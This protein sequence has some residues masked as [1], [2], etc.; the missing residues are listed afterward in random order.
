MSEP[1]MLADHL[2][3]QTSAILAVWRA[4][5]ERVGDVSE[6]GRLSFTDFVD[7]IPDLL[8]RLA[9]RLRGRPADATVTGKKHGTVRWR[10]GYDIAEVVNE[11]GHL[12]T[13]LTRATADFA[14]K[15]DWD[16][17]SLESANEAIND[18]LDEA[19]AESVRQFQEDSRAETQKA[20]AEVKRR[21]SAIEEA[22]ISAKL[23]KSKLRTILNSLPVGVWVVDAEGT[24]I[25]VNHEAERIQ[26]F[27]HKENVGHA[28]VHRLGGNERVVRTDGT[29]YRP[30]ELPI[31][32]ALRGETIPDEE[33]TWITPSH[34]S[35]V[36]IKAAPLTDPS[37]AIIGAVAAVQDLTNRRQ[38]EAQL[39]H[40]RDLSRTITDTLGEG[41]CTLDTEGRVTFVNPAAVQMLGWSAAEL[42][43]EKLHERIHY[44]RS[45]GTP[46]PAERCPILGV[47]H[48]GGTVQG[49][50]VF[51][52]KDGTRFI[53]AYT[54]SAIVSGGRIIGLAEAFR[55]VT[56]RKGLEARLAASEAQF[57]TIAEKSPV[58]IWRTDVGA[59]CDYVNQTWVEF[60]GPWV[61]GEFTER[62]IAALHPDDRDRVTEQYT[63]AFAR[64]ESFEQIYRI[65]RRDGQ[66]RWLS[67][68]AT[69][70]RDAAGTFLGY[71]G[72]CLDITERINLERALEQQREL[73]EEASRH[74][75]RLV[76]ALSHDARTPLNAVVLAA[77]LLELHFDENAD[78]EVQTCLRTIRHSVRNVLDLLGDLLDLSKIDAGA[79]PAE[80]TRFPVELVLAECVASIEP[81]AR[82]KGLDLRFEPGPLTGKTIETDR[83]KLKQIVS[84]L[85]SNALRYTERGHVR[86][87]TEQT[88]DQVRIV[89]E[90]TGI[91]IDPRDQARIFDEFAVI[92]HPLR[93]EA[94]TGLGLAICR[95]LASLLMGEISLESAVGKGSTFRLVLPSSVLTADSPKLGDRDALQSPTPD[96]GAILIAED[97]L[98]SRQTLAR[99]LRR[100]GFRVLE[101]SNGHDALALVR[102]ESVMAV[103]MDVNMPLMD[104]IE[105]TLT[106]R[107]DPRF[108]ELPIFALTGDVTLVNQ[109]RIGE[110]GVNG[111]LE[112]PVTW[113]ALK[114]ALATLSP[115]AAE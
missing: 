79:T 87:Y 22:W 84:N 91:G 80:I 12:R 89:V 19:T 23:E 101:A 85:L 95:R 43:G 96:Q 71:L 102:G 18:V 10:Q 39:R 82:L 110:A 32:R 66:Y 111:Y 99:V 33:L 77:Q 103:L 36:A 26:G 49:D 31:V 93:T 5:V 100:M 75:T 28:N 16:I 2:D 90:D 37:G 9:E 46:Y 108:R 74:K 17:A 30:D 105:A 57:R 41:L 97:H 47:L 72:S 20:L 50:E 48:S 13:A 1:A 8:D 6:A 15:H 51:I 67:D 3:R 98:E 25:G 64:R 62:W 11:F 21:Q 76:S 83:S 24:I 107:A 44:E 45:D 114:Q 52:R 7:H 59:R 29:P 63:E 38:T 104:G 54:A 88:D 109:H 70:Y 14:R 113:D 92:D 61:D 86:L 94:G 55:D 106:L 73:A 78:D 35:T 34:T 42:L 60:M 68:R 27:P 58:M 4:T 40:E 53:G 65:R 115:R 69:P 112:K 56:E 81:Q